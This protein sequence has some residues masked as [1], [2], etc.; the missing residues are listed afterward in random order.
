M[1][2]CAITSRTS[3]IP[4]S[5]STSSSTSAVRHEDANAIFGVRL[6]PIVSA[7]SRRDRVDEPLT[8]LFTMPRRPPYP[9]DDFR[10]YCPRRVRSRLARTLGRSPRHRVRPRGTPRVARYR[11]RLQRPGCRLVKARPISRSADRPRSICLGG[12]RLGHSGRGLIDEHR[13]SGRPRRG[14]VHSPV[15]PVHDGFLSRTSGVYRG[16]MNSGVDAEFAAKLCIALRSGNVEELSP[17]GDARMLERVAAPI[18]C[19]LV[20]FR[21]RPGRGS[22]DRRYCLT[23]AKSFSPD[24]CELCAS[25]AVASPQPRAGAGHPAWD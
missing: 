5:N 16:G 11:L 20:G 25:C 8:W 23:L 7:Y 10:V 3:G 1:A 24:R 18:A 6:Q 4:G 14:H 22:A 9:R 12:L 19:F 2:S 21:H 17:R 15:G 13:P